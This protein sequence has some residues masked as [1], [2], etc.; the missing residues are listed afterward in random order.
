MCTS[1][2]V[3]CREVTVCVQFFARLYFREFHKSTG[4]CENENSKICTHT[5][6]V[7]SCRPPLAKLKSQ[8]LLGAG[9][10]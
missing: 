1:R 7:C 10:S 4:V 5:V 9:H 2:S 8:E 3:L 6:Q